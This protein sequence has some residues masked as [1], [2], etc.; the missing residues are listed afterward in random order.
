MIEDIVHRATYRHPPEL[1]WRAIATREGLDAWM[2]VNDFEEAKVGH[3]F[4]FRDK[5]RPFWDGICDCE[6]AEADAPRRF[7]LRWGLN[8]RGEPTRLSF[9]LTPTSD[10]GTTL[11]LRHGGLNGVMGWFM[12]KGMDKGWRRM[13]E[14]SIP[15]VAD[16]MAKGAVPSRDEVARVFRGK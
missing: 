16:G 13:V 10:G 15:L 9:E 4:R 8:V 5:P 14:R 2:M 1:V 6:V 7:V 11:E 3:R 12:K